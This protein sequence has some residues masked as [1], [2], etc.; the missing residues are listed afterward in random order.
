MNTTTVT[1]PF[2]RENVAGATCNSR[3]E[4]S[5][6]FEPGFEIPRHDS[7]AEEQRRHSHPSP[8]HVLPVF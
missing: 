8:I 6:T 3:T 7:T 1:S 2:R 4:T 5:S